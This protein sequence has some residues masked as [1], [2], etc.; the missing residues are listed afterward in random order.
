MRIESVIWV[1][2]L[3]LLLGGLGLP[4]PE[5]PALVGGGYA[6]YRGVVAT[7]PG[8]CLWYVAIICGDIVLFA[9]AR[10][11][12]RRP[13][14]SGWLKRWAG[15]KRF[16]RYQ[17]AFLSW[18]GWTLFL[19]RFTFGIRAVAYFAAGAA[20]YPWIRFLLVDSASVAIQMLVFVG[21][22]YYAGERVE[23]AKT[24]GTKIALLLSLAAI[25]TVIFTWI[26]TL[27]LRR[28]SNR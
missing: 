8:L 3:A 28:L 14:P 15:K 27:F 9:V 23:L 4:V 12:F 16:D 22:G 24:T 19:A 25:L 11:F 6:I 2:A 20:S 13:S 18:G 17:R 1:I 26:Y 5:N 7:I 10:W 21:I